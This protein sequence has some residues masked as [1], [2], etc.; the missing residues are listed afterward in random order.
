[1]VRRDRQST[2]AQVQTK[3]Q[4]IM[5]ACNLI[6]DG[7]INMDRTMSW[8]GTRDP[9]APMIFSFR[10]PHFMA[11]TEHEIEEESATTD[12]DRVDHF[13]D[14][15]RSTLSWEPPEMGGG[16]P[17]E[18]ATRPDQ[19]HPKRNPQRHPN[20]HRET[21]HRGYRKTRQQGYRIWSTTPSRA[22]RWQ[23]QHKRR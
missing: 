15:E 20:P 14:D 21:S 18:G 22:W 9:T 12:W 13:E 1:M 4:F 17:A 5:H 6:E 23:S 10:P 3:V 2:G 8:P 11:L 19:A 16:K 7:T